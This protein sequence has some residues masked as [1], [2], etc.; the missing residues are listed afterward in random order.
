MPQE[1][2]E[3]P[4]VSFAKVCTVR[5]MPYPDDDELIDRWYQDFDYFNFKLRAKKTALSVTNSQKDS[6]KNQLSNDTEL[7]GLECYVDQARLTRRRERRKRIVKVVLKEQEEQ[8]L[9]LDFDPDMMAKGCKFI[10]TQSATEA[11]VDAVKL[12]AE[13]RA[14]I[15]RPT[16]P[17]KNPP[18]KSRLAETLQAFARARGMPSRVNIPPS[19]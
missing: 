7:L 6:L 1:L 13:L 12:Y 3:R 15:P 5:R 14:S 16:S 11:R 17:K 18:P 4:T 8:E 10:S 2:K 9:S 19:A